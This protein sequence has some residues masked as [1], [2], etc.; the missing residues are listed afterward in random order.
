[1]SDTVNEEVQKVIEELCA[2]QKLQRDR[3][4]A[5]MK[6]SF[7]NLSPAAVDSLIINLIL[8]LENVQR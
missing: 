3:G 5:H 4:L 7:G 8:I 1:M 6:T 2:T